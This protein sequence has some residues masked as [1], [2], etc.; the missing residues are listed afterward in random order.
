MEQSIGQVPWRWEYRVQLD[1]SLEDAAQRIPRTIANLEQ[2]ACGVIMHGYA[3]DL[4]VVAHMLAGLRCPL[5]VLSPSELRG[6]LLALAEHTRSIA[7]AP[8]S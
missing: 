3:D 6:H 1:L 7:M 8:G 5:I 4:A 2:G